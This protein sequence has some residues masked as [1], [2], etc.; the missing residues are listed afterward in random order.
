MSKVLLGKYDACFTSCVGGGSWGEECLCVA[1]SD[2][3]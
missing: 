1:Y 3:E 2:L